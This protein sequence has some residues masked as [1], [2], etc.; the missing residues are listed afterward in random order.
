M[1]EEKNVKKN[2]NCHTTAAYY[3]DY[4]DEMTISIWRS[5]A[6]LRDDTAYLQTAIHQ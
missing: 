1:F 3:H 2:V 6:I 5:L 4:D